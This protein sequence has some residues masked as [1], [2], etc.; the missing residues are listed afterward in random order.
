MIITN[1]SVENIR[2]INDDVDVLKFNGVVVWERRTQHKLEWGPGSSEIESFPDLCNYSEGFI[3]NIESNKYLQT[4][5][6]GTLWKFAQVLDI[7]IRELF[8]PIDDNK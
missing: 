4:F 6:L 7:D 8:I 1:E 5:S 3:M 2:F